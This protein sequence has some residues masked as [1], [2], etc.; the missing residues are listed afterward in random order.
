VERAGIENIIVVVG[1]KREE[2]WR[3]VEEVGGGK[4]FL[5]RFTALALRLLF[6]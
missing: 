5:P 6:P 3:R 4:Y 1:L 2:R